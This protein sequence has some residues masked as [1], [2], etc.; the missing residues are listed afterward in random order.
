MSK[1]EGVEVHSTVPF[2][3]ISLVVPS[4]AGVFIDYLQDQLIVDGV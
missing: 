2:V 4:V 3:H 1:G